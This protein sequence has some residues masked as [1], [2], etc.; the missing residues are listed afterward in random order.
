MVDGRWIMRGG[1]VLTMD[2]ERI[3]ADGTEARQDRL[4][5]PVRQPP[6]SRRAARVRAAADIAGRS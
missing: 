1:E 5:T 4:A 2:E 6:R 3:V